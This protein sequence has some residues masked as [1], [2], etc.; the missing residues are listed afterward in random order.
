VL[1]VANPYLGPCPSVQTDWTPLKDRF[2]PFE[3]FSARRRPSEE[4]MWQFES[5]V[6]P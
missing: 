2:D 4:D 1:G 6:A 5:F 3:K